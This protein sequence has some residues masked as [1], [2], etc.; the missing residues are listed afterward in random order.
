MNEVIKSTKKNAQIQFLRAVFCLFIIFYHFTFRYCQLY[1]QE[2]IFSA[3]FFS[4]FA[5]FGL[6]PFFVL[7]GF[8][9]IRR[10]EILSIKEKIIYWLKKILIIYSLYLMAVVVIYLFSLTGLFGEDRTVSFTT[11][12]QNLFFINVITGAKYVDGAHWYIFALLCLYFFAIIYD[13][14]IAKN[15]NLGYLYWVILFLLSI[16]VLFLLKF[17]PSGSVISNIFRAINL[18]LC[19]GYFPY[20]FI[21]L[22]LFYFDY[23][24]I[25]CIKNIV[26]LVV[27][28]LSLTYITIENWVYLIIVLVVLPVIVIALLRKLTI[29]EKI[30][31]ILFIGDASFSIY[32]FHQNIGYMLLNIFTKG[33]NY[34]FSVFLVILI[35]LLVFSLF[36]FYVE[37]NIKKAI[38]K[39]KIRDKNNRNVS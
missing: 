7:T 20:I 22:A 37:G 25:K 18:L 12:I 23:D 5:F 32:L 34:Y 9:L 3:H 1:N 19:Q 15:K 17:L 16:V 2:S 39:I 10:K 14:F 13:F 35:I 30:K 8:F 11:F 4:F 36:G 29:L 27:V 6:I 24:N 28:I 33:I 31:P 21:G 38:S 26:L